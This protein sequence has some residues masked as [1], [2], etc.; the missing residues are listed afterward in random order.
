DGSDPWG[1]PNTDWYDATLKTW[2]PQ[3]RHNLQL[4]GGSENFKYLTSLGYQNQ[5]AYYK[6]AATGY[7]QY[8]MRINL[9]AN[10]NKYIKTSVGIL[11]RQENRFFP[12]VGANAIFRMQMRG[13]P[14]QPAYWPNGLP[15]PDIENGQN[16]VVITTNET[17]YDR[18]TR[19]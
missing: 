6:D 12:T 3:S 11:A 10:I 5:D 19:Y 17:G 16:P 8:D 2:S 13:I 14:T 7:K 9:D 4:T 18:D 1:H 15:G